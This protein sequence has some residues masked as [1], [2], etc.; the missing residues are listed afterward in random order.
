MKRFVLVVGLC[1]VAIALFPA[2]DAAV[3]QAP[4]MV[5]P[6]PPRQVDRSAPP[7][8]RDRFVLT[9]VAQFAATA[10]VLSRRDYRFDAE[11]GVSPTDLALGWGRMSDAGVIDAIAI[12][13]SG[14]WY[15]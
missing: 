10:R 6:E 3:A 5:A 7:I 15:R 11:A 8:R 9:P 4:G 13:Q 12:T 1:V 2:R 14:R